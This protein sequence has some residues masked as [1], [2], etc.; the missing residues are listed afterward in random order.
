MCIRDSA[1]SGELL[2]R[3]N[4]VQYEAPQSS[5]VNVKGNVFT[6]NPYNPTSDENLVDLRA[7]NGNANYYSDASGN[8][9][10]PANNG[11]ANYFLEGNFA[12]VRTNSY[13][14]N[15]NSS[16]NNPLVTFDNSNSTIQE[17]T[18][19]YAVN[20]IHT[21]LKNTFPTFTGLDISM[22]TNDD[23]Q[24]SCN[25]YFDGISINFYAEGGGCHATAKIV[26]V[27]YHEY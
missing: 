23:E 4:E 3:K 21:H 5:T 15:F 11:S 24:R 19:F 22:E 20:K 14:Q 13:V 2:M 7:T 8:F 18:A 12:E 27:V 10:F 9:N 6:S 17:R 25:A 26:V 1:N 16:L